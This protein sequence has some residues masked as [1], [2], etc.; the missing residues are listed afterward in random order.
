MF[1]TDFRSGRRL[2]VVR[3]SDIARKIRL[4]DKTGIVNVY[5]NAPQI[6]IV[7][8]YI[9][10]INSLWFSAKQVPLDAY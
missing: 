10:Y 5:D 4:K 6:N 3:L 1:Q 8:E 9:D 7:E 2:S